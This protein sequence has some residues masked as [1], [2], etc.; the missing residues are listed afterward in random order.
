MK[1]VKMTRSYGDILI[2]TGGRYKATGL[3]TKNIV[4]VEVPDNEADL[5]K[6]IGGTF[7]VEDILDAGE[8]FTTFTAAKVDPTKVPDDAN[9]EKAANN[10]TQLTLE[11]VDNN[12]YN[13]KADFSKLQ[14]Y[15]SLDEKVGKLGN[16]KWMCFLI[17]TNATTIKDIIYNGE[18]LTDDDVA[19]A[20]LVGGAEGDIVVYTYA[21]RGTARFTLTYQKK[22]C[23]ITLNV[24][25]TQA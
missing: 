7:S 11:K 21:G 4:S 23:V 6:R 24:I 25:N 15:T 19:E 18:A 20:T 22:T 8:V 5:Y 14:A 17:T 1:N 2:R 9:K 13:L 16:K 10:Q 12:T 3:K